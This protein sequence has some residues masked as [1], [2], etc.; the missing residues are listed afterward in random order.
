MV[1]L[2]MEAKRR[3]QQRLDDAKIER[4]LRSART[5]RS[6]GLTSVIAQLVIQLRCQLIMLGTRPQTEWK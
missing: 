1:D 6:S 4:L 3:E 5:P 2:Y